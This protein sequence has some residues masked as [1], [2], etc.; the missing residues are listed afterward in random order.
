[1]ENVISA[2]L[3]TADNGEVESTVRLITLFF[4]DAWIVCKPDEEELETGFELLPQ[5]SIIELTRAGTAI[6]AA[7]W[8]VLTKNSRLVSFINLTFAILFSIVRFI[9]KIILNLCSEKKIY[10]VFQKAG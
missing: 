3:P 10:K 4:K 9:I 7:P 6:I 8:H 5:L 2:A 1:M